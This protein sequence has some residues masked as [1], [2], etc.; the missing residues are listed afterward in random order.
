MNIIIVNCFDTYEYRVDLL[1]EL[2]L[3]NNYNTYV[4]TSDYC[5]IEKKKRTEAKKKYKYLKT[6]EYKKNLSYDRLYSHYN[7]SKEVY[8]YLKRRIKHIDMLWVLAPPNSLIS[9]TV[10]LKCLKRDLKIVV[11]LIDLW[12]ETLPLPIIKKSLVPWRLLRS[13]NIKKSDFVVTECDL[14]RKTLKRELQGINNTTLYLARKNNPVD[15]DYNLSCDKIVLC[16]LG[17][18]NNLIDIPM[19]EKIIIACRKVKPVE[20]H[21]I[22]DGEK[23]NDLL[24]GCS[25]NGASIIDHGKVYSREEKF[26]IFDL[27][28]FGLNIMKKSVCVGLTMKSMDYFE[29]GLPIINS[30]YGD[31]WEII[32]KYK[33]GINVNNTLDMNHILKLFALNISTEKSLLMRNECRNFFVKHLTE[34]VFE[35]KVLKILRDINV[36]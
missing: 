24:E 14:Y 33:C 11:D 6:L 32:E 13:N 18:I 7:F 21:I 17:S 16:Y 8:N 15:C 26:K 19:I 4:L 34:K 2:F 3:K 1:L 27:C 30:I 12:P 36:G 20:I 23:K 10:K 22:G 25:K 28:H 5:H 31:T 29:Y 35:Y 9:E